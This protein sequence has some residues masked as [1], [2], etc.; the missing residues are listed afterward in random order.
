ML[1]LA[2]GTVTK[3]AAAGQNLYP[4]LSPDGETVAFT[5]FLGSGGGR[6][7]KAAGIWLAPVS[8]GAPVQRT[9]TGLCPRWS[10]DGAR[11]AYADA[12]GLHVLPRAGGKAALVL[13][14]AGL[15]S[16]AYDWSPAGRTIAA[17]TARGRLTVIDTETK[18]NRVIGPAHTFDFAWSPDGSRLLVAGGATAKACSSLWIV[19]PDGSSLRRL[20]S[21]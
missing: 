5:R 8:R 17:V 18:R 19:H 14:G 7:E 16:C 20:R 3:I 11:L 6:Y 9:K 10:P 1:H 4:A 12:G 21:C 15:P 13:R 2:G